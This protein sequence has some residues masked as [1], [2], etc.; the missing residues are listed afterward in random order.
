MR[1]VV[2]TSSPGFTLVEL[3]IVIAIIGFLAAAVLVAVD[4]V[5]R[6]QDSRDAR[7]YSEV[8]AI[9]NSILTKQVDDRSLYSGMSLAP[10]IT[11]ATNAQVIVSSDVGVA[12]DTGIAGVSNYPGC[13]QVL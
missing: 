3:L 9:L 7:R 11:H 1:R 10:I 13:N 4:P 12:C 6:I 2:R 5:K 8:N